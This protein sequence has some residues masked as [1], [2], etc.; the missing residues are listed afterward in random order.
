MGDDV[1]TQTCGCTYFPGH[2]GDKGK[3]RGYNYAC[4]LERKK[5]RK[6]ITRAEML[7][8]L[9]LPAGTKTSHHRS[10]GEE[11]RRQ[12]KR[13]TIFLEMVREGHRQS[14]PAQELISSKH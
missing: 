8:S 14:D 12:K 6:E 2:A 4:R 5:E 10:P 13:F 7:R 11:S 3:Y 1:I 9:G